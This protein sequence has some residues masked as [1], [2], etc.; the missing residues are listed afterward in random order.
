MADRVLLRLHASGLRTA[1]ALELTVPLDPEA[2]TLGGIALSNSLERPWNEQLLARGDDDIW[3]T[4]TKRLVSYP[5][6]GSQNCFALEDGSFWFA[7]RNR[8]VADALLTLMP[9][10][11]RMLDIGGGNGYVARGLE[12][13]GYAV[14]LLEPN[15]TGSRNARARGIADVI[16]ATF[17]PSLFIPGRFRIAGLFD[18][19]EHIEDDAGTLSGV[20]SILPPGGLVVLTVP[21]FQSMFSADDVLSGHFRRYTRKMM[22]ALLRTSGFEILRVSYFMAPLALPVLLVRA[23][24]ARLGVRP[25]W[26]QQRHDRD[27]GK[28][29][30]LA[31][32]ATAILAAEARFLARGGQLPFGTSCLAIGRVPIG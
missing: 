8:V 1:I 11:A 27:H 22:S 2:T 18:V 16:C 4:P 15:E 25:R 14:T 28:G 10:P 17:E 20:R 9:P 23:L 13:A 26:N 3:R 24:P 30:V 7:H 21:A 12:A 32:L 6:E 31:P 5:D 29:S 19:I